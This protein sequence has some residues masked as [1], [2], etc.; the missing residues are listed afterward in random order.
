MKRVACRLCGLVGLED[1]WDPAP[2]VCPRCLDERMASLLGPLGER[3][4][5]DGPRA[6][7]AWLEAEMRA[8]GWLTEWAA[9]QSAALAEQLGLVWP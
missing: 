3:T 5:R 8:M 7:L 2:G 9:A 6:A 4:E 1:P